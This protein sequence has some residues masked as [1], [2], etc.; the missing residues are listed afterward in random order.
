MSR[1]FFDTA[2]NEYIKNKFSTLIQRSQIWTSSLGLNENKQIIDSTDVLG[3]T[4]NPNVFA[5]E[6]LKTFSE[7]KKR[8]QILSELVTKIRGGSGGVVFIQV[9]S[10]KMTDKET[11]L[12]AQTIANWGDGIT[13][14]GIKIPPYNRFLALVDK[15]NEYLEVNVTGVADCATALKSAQFPVNWISI[16]PGRMEE[17]GINAQEHVCFVMSSNTCNT[18]WNV[19]TGSMRTIEGLKWCFEYGTIPTIGK[20]VFDLLNNDNINVLNTQPT[21][22]V[23]SPFA[24]VNIDASRTLSEQFFSQMDELGTEVK[25]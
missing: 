8:T 7:W 18:R 3:I 13:K 10:S 19:I 12:W 4:T 2:D 25:L 21:E 16:I 23:P 1:F 14:I 5:K 15:L 24:P 20:R 6:N 22:L 11:L 9:P 17:V